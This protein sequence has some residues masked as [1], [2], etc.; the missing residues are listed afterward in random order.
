MISIVSRQ[1]VQK[2]ILKGSVFELTARFPYK[3]DPTKLKRLRLTSHEIKE[4]VYGFGK[5]P[6]VPMLTD[7]E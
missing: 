5:Q 1:F 6:V 4:T 7:Q 2:M 3:S